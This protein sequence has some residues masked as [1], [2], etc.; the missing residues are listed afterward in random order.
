MNSE[1]KEEGFQYTNDPWENDP[2]LT[3]NPERAAMVERNKH[4]T[5]K[6]LGLRPG[7]FKDPED[8]AAYAEYLRQDAMQ[9]KAED[10]PPAAS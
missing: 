2:F 1:K 7:Q 6:A 10:A 5:W 8:R 3:Q 4:P 9:G